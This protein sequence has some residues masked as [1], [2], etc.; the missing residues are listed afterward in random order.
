V[1]PPTAAERAAWKRLPF[2]EKDFLK[3]RVQAKA[4]TGLRKYS[5]LERLWALPTF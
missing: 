2:K 4:L 1:K 5:V 3:R